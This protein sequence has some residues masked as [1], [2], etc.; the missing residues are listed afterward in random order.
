MRRCTSPVSQVLKV[1]ERNRLGSLHCPFLLPGCHLGTKK[2]N[3]RVRR[4]PLKRMPVSL[5]KGDRY[6][7]FIKPQFDGSRHIPLTFL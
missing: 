2:F 1:F 6:A 7:P 3:P 5:G 4:V